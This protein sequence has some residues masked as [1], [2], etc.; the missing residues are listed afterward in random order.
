MRLRSARPAMTGRLKIAIQTNLAAFQKNKNTITFRKRYLNLSDVKTIPVRSRS[1]V[2]VA[3]CIYPKLPVPTRAG[4]LERLFIE[5]LDQDT[6]IEAFAKVHEY[7]HD[8]LRRPYLKS[9]GMPAQYSPDFLVRT[10]MDVYAVEAKAQSALSDENVQRK[11]RAA[12][13]WCGQINQ[14]EPHCDST[15]AGT[16]SCSVSRSSASGT[17]RVLGV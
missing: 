5:W 3:K 14:L 12:L 9:D 4:G 8:F 7:R 1:C 15:S 10:D 6:R 2:E 17:A 13:A 16:T 11:Q